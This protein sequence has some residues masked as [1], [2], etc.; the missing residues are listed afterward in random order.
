MTEDEV[1]SSSA[2]ANAFRVLR[3]HGLWRQV[4][5]SLALVI[6]GFIEG[7]GITTLLLVQAFFNISVVLG[8]FPTKGF[9]LP[10]ISYG[11]SSL[12]VTLA[13]LGVLM[14]V[15]EHAG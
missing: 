11:G 1:L 2:F 8:L 3:K 6:S 7:L 13:L 15:S 12:L 9:P 10:M 14:N 4:P 5:L